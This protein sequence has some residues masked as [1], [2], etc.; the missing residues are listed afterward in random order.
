MKFKLLV[1]LLFLTFIRSV[2]SMVE[3]NNEM[4][5]RGARTNNIRLV[6]ELLEPKVDINTQDE[7]GDTALTLAIHMGYKPMVELLLDKGANPNI[8][9]NVFWGYTALLWAVDKDKPDIVKL[10]LEKGVNP[11]IQDNFDNTALMIAARNNRILIVRLLLDSGASLDLVNNEGKT[12]LDLAQEKKYGPIIKL[13]EEKIR[14][15]VYKEI[16]DSGYLLPELA[17]IVSEYV[18]CPKE[19]D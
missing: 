7:N 18:V 12:A 1:S 10:L 2:Y 3:S 4:L 9:N 8:K 16:A 17:N 15:K 13:I 11:N 6:R 5:L 14:Q 19:K